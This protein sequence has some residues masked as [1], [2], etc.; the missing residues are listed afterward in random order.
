MSTSVVRE[1]ESEDDG[2]PS[3]KRTKVDEPSQEAPP[4][5]DTV[6]DTDTAP[7]TSSEPAAKLPGPSIETVEDEAILPPSH[8]LLRAPR[9]IGSHSGADLRIMET[10]VGISEYV[11]SDIP[12]IEGIIKQRCVQ[13]IISSLHHPDIVALQVHRL[14]G[15]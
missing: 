5:I 1:R 13:T 10:D 3:P 6:M 4:E 7:T 8:A 15:V 14:F 11:G 2:G 9:H 12:K